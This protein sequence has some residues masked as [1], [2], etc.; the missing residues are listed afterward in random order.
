MDSSEVTPVKDEVQR[1]IPT[2][3]RPVLAAV[4]A[5]FVRGDY[6]LRC[7]VAGVRTVSEETAAQIREY[8]QDYGA[9]LTA[10]PDEAWQS[11]VCT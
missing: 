2:A 8:V 9:R 5:A 3:W 11:S 7:P 4:V 6:G 10:L 1:P